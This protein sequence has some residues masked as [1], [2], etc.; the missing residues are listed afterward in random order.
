MTLGARIA[1]APFTSKTLDPVTTTLFGIAPLAMPLDE[2]PVG[3]IDFPAA[4]APWPVAAPVVN[5]DCALPLNMGLHNSVCLSCVS[6]PALCAAGV[7]KLKT[8][9]LWN[10][11]A[12]ST[13]KSGEKMLQMAACPLLVMRSARCGPRRKNA[14]HDEMT[15]PLFVMRRLDVRH[16]SRTR[17]SRTLVNL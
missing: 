10:G 7:A 6:L 4:A 17:P 14:D 1:Y 5:R 12:K 2:A 8:V 15:C 11:A 16:G 9:V 13:R 3:Q